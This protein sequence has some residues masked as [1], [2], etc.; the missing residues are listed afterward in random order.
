MGFWGE[1]AAQPKSKDVAKFVGY[2]REQVKNKPKEKTL[3]IATG[4]MKAAA[5]FI[6]QEHGPKEA[7]AVLDAVRDEILAVP[8]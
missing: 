5:W 4:T 2:I 7:L 1:P 6:S 8:Q 3:E